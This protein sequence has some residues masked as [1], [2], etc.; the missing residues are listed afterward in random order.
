MQRILFAA[1][2]DLTMN[3]NVRLMFNIGKA[4]NGLRLICEPKPKLLD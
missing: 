4:D 2:F 1:I 3:A